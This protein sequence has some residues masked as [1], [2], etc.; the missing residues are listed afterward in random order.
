VRFHAFAVAAT[1][2]LVGVAAP[3][4][5]R[6]QDPTAVAE[7]PVPTL[8]IYGFAM[9]DAIYDINSSHPDWK[10]TVRPSK[11][12]V[13]CPGD[14]GCGEDGETTLSVRQSR[15]G[16][17]GFAPTPVG[18]LDTVFEFE[19]F[20][21]GNDAGET[22]IRLRHAYAELGMVGGGQTWSMFM[23]P[24]VFP[25]TIDYWGP[26]GMVFFR[27]A[28]LRIT[29]VRND[30]TTVA[31]GIEHPGAAIDSGKSGQIDPALGTNLTQWN[32]FP[33]VSGHVR[34]HG[35]WGHVQLAGIFRV[36]GVQDRNEF[37]EQTIGWGANLSGI[38][39]VAKDQILAQVVYGEGIANYM[40]DGGADLAPDQAPPDAEAE[41]VPTLGWLLYLNHKWTDQFTSCIGYS[42]HRQFNTDGQ[43]ETAFATGQYGN[44]NF[45]YK[46]VPDYLIGPE[47]VF[48][49]LEQN[50]G[51]DGMDMRVQVSVKGKFGAQI[52]GK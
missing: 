25:D 38:A 32:Q 28:Q 30:T 24:D 26:A 23:D 47:F 5:A 51:S 18:D 20:G 49:R 36:L 52:R 41:A 13:N 11:I 27:N 7:D 4:T 35:D 17:R 29:P 1:A 16:V 44:A 12:P 40:Q 37:S 3:G 9:L 43:T 10:S 48:G 19:M 2:A 21:T 50:D 22:T 39:N 15:F 14:P 42:E 6:A 8:D 33:D 34:V 31:V 45:L 46:P